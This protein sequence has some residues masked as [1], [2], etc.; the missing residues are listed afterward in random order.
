MGTL[1]NLVV[2]ESADAAL[3]KGLYR[4]GNHVSTAP[5]ITSLPRQKIPR[6]PLPEA[7][8]RQFYQA[9]DQI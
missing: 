8:H 2:S 3:S 7:L 5:E 4:A 9:H 6:L 1:V